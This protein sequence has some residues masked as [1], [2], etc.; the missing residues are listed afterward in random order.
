[1]GVDHKTV[2]SYFAILEVTPLGFML[3]PWQ[4]P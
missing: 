2:G 1:V 4:A 3:E